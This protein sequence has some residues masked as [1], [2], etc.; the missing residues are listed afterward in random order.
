MLCKEITDNISFDFVINCMLKLPIE[1][2][3]LYMTVNLL[4]FSK[5]SIIKMS[6]AILQVYTLSNL[7]KLAIFS[8]PCLH[9]AILNIPFGSCKSS[10][11]AIKAPFSCIKSF[12]KFISTFIGPKHTPANLRLGHY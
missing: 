3:K 2:F 7:K 1:E 6:T 12:F 8:T 10:K 5:E 4:L 9:T 11:Q